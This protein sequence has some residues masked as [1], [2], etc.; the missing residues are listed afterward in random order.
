MESSRIFIRGLPSGFSPEEFKTH[1]SKQA[2]V[3]DMKVIPHRRIGYV[4]YKSP[5]DAAKAVKYHNKSFIRTS[6]IGVELA[7]SIEE[8][9][10]LRPAA[11]ATDGVKRKHGIMKGDSLEKPR[12]DARSRLDPHI[13]GGQKGDGKA[14]LQEFLD[15]MQPPSKSKIWENPV[16]PTAQSP[17]ES[18]LLGNMHTTADTRS[19]GEYEPVPKKLKEERKKSPRDKLAREPTRL[20]DEDLEAAI[21]RDAEDVEKTT[22]KATHEAP[23]TAQ[24]ASDTVWLRSRTSRL[25]GLLDDNVPLESMALP[26]S[27]EG[28]DLANVNL[29]ELIHSSDNSDASSQTDQIDTNEHFMDNAPR[30]NLGGSK[31]DNRRLFVRNLTYTTTE[32]ELRRHLESGDYGTIEEV[33]SKFLFYTCVLPENIS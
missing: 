1:F 21:Q 7:R 3:T 14:K 20:Q 25:L 30:F 12:E 17:A 10:A 26:D 27:S 6:R 16:V 8:Q 29:P 31:Q 4:G 13:E 28:Q 9:Y 19:D 32:D 33:R 23:A 22:G 2:N 24:S 5:G 11:N 18:I 15:V